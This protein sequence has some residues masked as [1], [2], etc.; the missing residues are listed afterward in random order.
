MEREAT[1]LRRAH[2]L[3]APRELD[4]RFRSALRAWSANLERLRVYR[5][6]VDGA[7]SARHL[8]AAIDRFAPERLRMSRDADP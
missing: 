3:A 7:G 8:K 4:A 2:A 5:H 6:A 1:V